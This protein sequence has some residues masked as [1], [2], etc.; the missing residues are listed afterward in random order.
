MPENLQQKLHTQRICSNIPSTSCTDDTVFD[1]ASLE[2]IGERSSFSTVATCAT[3]VSFN[4]YI[5]PLTRADMYTGFN[6][7]HLVCG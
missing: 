4:L 3:N 1:R 5:I 7:G 2:Y 6:R